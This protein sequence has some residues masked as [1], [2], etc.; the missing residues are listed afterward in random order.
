MG[1]LL[2]FLVIL[3]FGRKLLMKLIGFM[4]KAALMIFLLHSLILFFL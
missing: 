2:L 4:L 3:F 1:F